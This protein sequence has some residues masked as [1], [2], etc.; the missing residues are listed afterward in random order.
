MGMEVAV[1]W[2]SAALFIGLCSANSV[3][4][5]IY[6]T[7]NA[8]APCV[9]LMNAT[10]QIGCQSSLSGD[11][12]VIHLVEQESDLSWVL[13]D[14]PNPPYMVLLESNM[15][16]RDVMLSLKSSSRVSGVAAILPPS[17][18]PGQL[19]PDLKC[20]NDGFGLYSLNYGPEYAHCNET[21]W[22]PEGNG[23]SYDD[24]PFPVFMLKDENETQ[25][26]RQCYKDHNHPREG[27][28]PAF[29]LCAMQ[30]SSHMHGVKDTVT[31]MRRSRGQVSITLN[32]DGVCDPLSDFN[33]WTTTQPINKSGVASPEDRFVV[34]AA[35]LD[36]RSFFWEVAP[37]TDSAVSGFIVLLAAA[38]ALARTPDVESLPKNIM[39]LLF[40]GE[41][42]DYIG[43]SRMVYDMTN[44]KFPIALE[45]I[46]SFIELNQIGIGTS[47]E[48]WAHTDPVSLRNSTVNEQVQKLLASFSKVTAGMNISVRQPNQSQPLPPSS[49]QRFLRK[50]IIPGAVLTD[51]QASFTNRYYQ[52][53][54]DLGENIGLRYPD[55]L[56]PEEALN[57]ITDTAKALADVASLV[58]RTL[59]LQ[60]G[61]NGSLE[62][63][64]ANAQT[65]TRML[66][67]FVINWNNSWFH[68]IISQD[69]ND[70]FTKQ[71]HISFYVS[72]NEQTFSTVLVEH[73]LFNLTGRP[74]N[75]TEEQ[76]RDPKSIPH[77]DTNFFNY[78]WVQGAKAENASEPTP[79][80][81]RANVWLSR[82]LSPAFELADYSSTE[83][84]TWTES[85]WQKV[86]ARIFLVAS[87]ELEIITLVTGICVLITSMVLIHFL[88]AKS[89][90]LFS[91]PQEHSSVSY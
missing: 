89:N 31:C 80:C 87:R 12:G 24:F 85:R 71:K 26:I 83:Y 41:T 11:T 25:V 59:Y 62:N 84:S 68:S 75:L 30:L 3:E 16:T 72:V 33:V 6:I 60:A 65:V 34:A 48:I 90:I 29:P 74:A 69:K 56:T 27:A 42:F 35:R 2:I 7:L 9:R 88:N 45:N 22:N 28:A 58:A 8:T 73:V 67:G 51:H 70:I 32:T 38:E 64:T 10:H 36:S 23:L 18:A 52:S 13:S 79:Y 19:S 5:K 15:F 61:G 20:P 57:H 77:P 43:S 14:G 86:G 63:I 76:C 44:G 81:V 55:G 66:Y 37:G 78:I 40:Q 46:D 1:R 54:Y 17:P 82:A 50:R 49:F 91:G 39:F 4:K 47:S 21:L 53:V